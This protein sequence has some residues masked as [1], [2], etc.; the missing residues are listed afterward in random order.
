MNYSSHVQVGY[1]HGSPF[2]QL[3]DDYR[4]WTQDRPD[5]ALPGV[6]SNDDEKL[7]Y[8]RERYSGAS[9]GLTLLGALSTMKKMGMISQV[10]YNYATGGPLI[11]VSKEKMESGSF[12]I[13]HGARDER[14]YWGG[15]FMTSPLIGFH[16]LDD[17]FNWLEEFRKKEHPFSISQTEARLLG[18]I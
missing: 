8:L 9:D 13:S 11:R 18:Y 10:E 3:L 12:T 15:A 5:T 7:S 16:N 2:C 1:E 6:E 4:E 14:A 17:I